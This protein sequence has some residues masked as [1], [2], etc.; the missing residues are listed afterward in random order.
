MG[1][2][3]KFQDSEGCSQIIIQD[4]MGSLI[5]FIKTTFGSVNADLFKKWNNT[6]QQHAE[7]LSRRRHEVSQ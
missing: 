5:Q 2:R 6:Y 7:A 4:Y 3:D 1:N